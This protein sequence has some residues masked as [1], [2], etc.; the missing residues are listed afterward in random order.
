[1]QFSRT[2]ARWFPVPH[3]LAPQAAGVD[4]TDAS[5]KWLLFDARG[6]ALRLASYGSQKIPERVVERGTIKDTHTLAEV[7]GDIRKR[8]KLLFAHAALPEEDAYV[9]S[10]HVPPGSPP[11]QARAMIEFELE[12]RV[13]IPPS[14]AV[15]DYD[16]VARHDENGEEI[17][18]SVFP[19]D[20]AEGYTE[21]FAKAGI[22]LLSLEIEARSI[23]RA[24]SQKGRDLTTLL[25]D[26]GHARTGVAVLVHGI[27][28]FTSTIDIGGQHLSKAVMDAL[29]ISEDEAQ[30]FKNEHGL[31]PDPSVQK[32]VEAL[33]KVASTLADEIGRHYRFWETRRSE[34][35]ERSMP[36]ERVFLLG[37]SAN[38]KG[39]PEFIAG[40]VRALTERP[41]VWRNVF[42]FDDYIPPIDFRTSF[43]YATA[44]GLALR[45]R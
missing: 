13:P 7:L 8:E 45:N 4:I 26:C 35:N 25:V 44:V 19:R 28:I 5:V 10:M 34:R 30:V 18:V 20:L 23:A 17:A 43:Q 16:V 27:P 3:L 32:G 24:V 38:L 11:A 1:M 41:N 2:L 22:E 40:K 21:S 31:V 42:S 15:F 9:F 39:F 14:E 33:E 36:V 37:G 29:S 6:E 12:G